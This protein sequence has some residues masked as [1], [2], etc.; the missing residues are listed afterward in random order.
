[1]SIKLHL[2]LNYKT[3]NVSRRDVLEKAIICIIIL[4]VI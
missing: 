4:V 2:I 1:M 3:I